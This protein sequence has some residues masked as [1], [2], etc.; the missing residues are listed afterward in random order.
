MSV[1]KPRLTLLCGLSASGK[2]QYI[3]NITWIKEDIREEDKSVVLS[4]DNLRKEICGSVEDQSMNGIVFQKFHN[5][6]RSNLKNG[7]DVVAEAT[8]IT[9]KSRRSILNVIKGIDCEKVCVVIVKPIGECKKDNI[10]REHPVPGH[11][12]DKQARKFQIPFLEEGWDKIQFVDHIHNKDKYNYR[13][14]STWIPEMY[15]DFDQKNPYHMESL[16]KHMADAYDFVKN[17]GLHKN[18]DYEMIIATKY[19]DMGKLYTQTFDEDGVAHYYGHENIGAYMMLV[20]EVANQHSL[21]VNHNIGDIA[22]YINYHM[23]PFQWKPNNTKTETKWAKRFGLKKYHN[24]WDM[25][26]ADLVASKRKDKDACTEILEN[27]G[28]DDES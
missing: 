19:H 25:H 2:S 3:E 7:I 20:Y 23:L 15:N 12:I 5:L 27:R 6:I 22:F 26:I 1:R 18:K 8:N 11:V 16:G 4:T 14:E 13:L 24:L 28:R 10:D 17:H 21:F 9:M